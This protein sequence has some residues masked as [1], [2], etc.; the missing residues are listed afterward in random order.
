MLTIGPLL[1]Y[2]LQIGRWSLDLDEIYT[3]RDSSESIATILQYDKPIYYLLCH[4]LLVAKWTPEI[5]IRLPSAVAAGLIA[6]CFYWLGRRKTNHH[7]AIITSLLVATHPWI[8]QHSQFGRFYSLMLLFSSVAVL[9]LYQWLGDRRRRW[10]VL[11]SIACLLATLTHA[12]AAALVPGSV[13]G[14]IGLFWF[15]NRDRQGLF[16]R[17]RLL[18]IAIVCLLLVAI[19]A[20]VLRDPFVD[21]WTA[22]HG[23]FGNYSTSSLLVGF[24]AFGGLQ[25]WALGVLPLAKT[26]KYWVGEDVFLCVT[27][28]AMV[29][30]FLALSYFGGGI[31]PRYLMASVPLLF[32]LA[33][34]HWS[35]IHS[36]LPSVRYQ[37]AL[38]AAILA[39]T[40]PAFASTMKDGNHC[41]YRASARYVDSLRL[42]NPIVA[43]SAHQLLGYYLTNQYDLRELRMLDDLSQ[44]PGPDCGGVAGLL[45]SLVEEAD[46]TKREL[47]LVSRED[48]RIRPPHVQTWF[49]SRF[50]TIAR[51]E[52]PRYDHRRNEIVIYEYRPR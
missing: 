32:V 21:W 39:A 5:A 16:T 35:V 41:D 10:I 46:S 33:G 13:L 30:P 52:K 11:F 26:R 17:H 23:Q 7:Q 14:A 43:A 1:F 49:N 24:V 12:T 3:L 4:M 45:H 28:M 22:Q 20:T 47:I 50:A 19:G 18:P 29:L 27:L 40:V 48:R 25:Y 2:V 6:P 9:S 15:E 34:R 38:A 42:D 36:Q 37:I 51:F 31:A 44:I 8:F